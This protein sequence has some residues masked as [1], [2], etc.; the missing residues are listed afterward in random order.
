MLLTS[1]LQLRTR[2]CVNCRFYLY[3]K[4]EPIIETSTKMEFAP[5][6]GAFKGHAEAMRGANLQPDHNLWFAVYDFNDEAKTGKNWRLIDR[7]EE[8][9]EWCPIG[10]FKNCCPYVPPGSIALPSQGADPTGSSNNGKPAAQSGGMMSFSMN[11]SLHDAAKISGDAYLAQETA[12]S[13]KPAPKEASP[14][15]AGVGWNPDA[16]SELSPAKKSQKKSGVGWNPGAF[17]EP[18]PEPAKKPSPKKKTG[19]G[20]NP[21][22]FSEPSPESAKKSSPKKVRETQVSVSIPNTYLT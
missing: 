5:F 16:V 18:S 2:D 19:V 17:S 21:N 20:W 8:G 6:N 15:K 3:S 12:G 22:A 10:K 13:S 4:T 11:T 7:S 9:A 14:K 1:F